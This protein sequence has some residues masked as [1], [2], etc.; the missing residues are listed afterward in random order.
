MRKQSRI[1]AWLTA[2]IIFGMVLIGPIAY[3]LISYNYMLG[4]LETEA[5][6]DS[7]LIT[8]MINANPEFWEF[9]HERLNELLARRLTEYPESRH[10]FNKQNTVVAEYVDTLKPPVIRRSRYVWDSAMVVGS[11][12]ISRSLIPLIK[13]SGFLAAASLT[14]GL[15]LFTILYKLPIR[16]IQRAEEELKKAYDELE[17]RVSER[18]AG[19]N[20]AN[21]GLKDEIAARKK[22][23]ERIHFLAYYD[24]VTGLPNRT[25]LQELLNRAIAYAQRHKTTGALLYFD[26]DNFK[27]INDTFGHAA[28][29]R[30]LQVAAERITNVLRKTDTI[31]RSTD[32]DDIVSRMGGDEYVVLL[33]NVNKLIDIDRVA[34][35]ILKEI[36][37]PFDLQGHEVVMSASMGICVF[38]SGGEN[39]EDLLK[40]ADAAM[41]HAKKQG[42][43]NYQFYSEA[44]NAKAIEILNLERDLR[45]AIEQEEILL[46]YQPKLDASSRKVVGMEALV[47]WKHKEKGMISPAEFIPLAEETGLI[48]PLGERV[49]FVACLQA[50]A[51]RTTGFE[52]A[53]ISVNLSVRQFDHKNLVDVI[54][55]TLRT[56]GLPPQNLELEITESSVMRKPEEAIAVLQKLKTLGIKISIDDFGT[57]YS[58]L[59]YLR[60]LPID[61][62]KIDRS[63]IMHA[64]TNP[65]DAAIVRGIIALA[66]SLKL[67]VIAEGVETEEQFEFLRSVDCDEVQGYLFSKPLPADQFSKQFVEKPSFGEPIQSESQYI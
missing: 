4:V 52:N 6:I 56:T 48:V 19:L 50:N 47:R 62:L 63:F 64:T 5:D 7:V 66:H 21:E 14:A 42:K 45:R 26:L 31:A 22:S 58:S 33:Q 23:E 27:R 36:S 39:A 28:G 18:T 67:K 57:G 49:L 2:L 34:N 60:R 61:S 59:S 40:N 30:L 44:L 17:R 9:E 15:A 24:S 38:P 20:K 35:R 3:F 12:E 54:E 16:T 13:K 43:N 11:V 41:Y 10:V 32:G 29:D 51:W 1:I 25:F 65:A 46:Y 53:H 37:Y 55:Q 8:Q